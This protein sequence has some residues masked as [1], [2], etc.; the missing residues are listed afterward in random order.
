[1]FHL[2][3]ALAAWRRSLSTNRT[4]SNDDL[5]EL[6]QH[7]RDQIA[8]LVKNG[9]SEKAA[10]EQAMATMGEY[11]AV[12]REYEKVYWEK[13]W[14]RG[15]LQNELS[16]KLS[17]FKNY[18]TVA[19]RNLRKQKGYS[20]INIAGLAL[21]LTCF[22]LIGLFIRFEW[23]YDR[24]HAKADRI[25]RIEK[26]NPGH[27]YLERDHF[28]IT[29][30]PLAA[31]LMEEFPEVEHAVYLDKVNAGLAYKDNQFYEDGLLATAHFFEVFGFHLL[32]GDSHTALMEPNAIV[33]T[34]SLTQKYFGEETALG[35][36][37]TVT[38]FGPHGPD[39]LEM[40]VTGIIEDVP[41]N[42]HLV[43]DYITPFASSA[44]FQRNRDSWGTST[45]YTYATLQAGQPV[46][47]FANKLAALSQTYND[48]EDNPDDQSY[49]Y[50][51]V[52]THIHLRSNANF[53]FGVNGNITYVYL[54]G[55]IAVLILLIAS[56]NYVNLATARSTTRLMEVGVRKVM[57]AHRL[58]L[59][60]QFMGEALLSSMAALLLAL[61]LVVLLLP[62]FNALTARAI[63]LD[64]AQDGP[65]LALL[66]LIGF[67]IGT[68]AGSYPA[69][70]MSAFQPVRMMKKQ[71]GHAQGKTTLRNVLVVAQFSVTIALFIGAVVIQRQLHYIQNA[72]SGIDRDHVVALP[73][74]DESLLERYDAIKN[75]LQQHPA[76]LGVTA[77]ETDPTMIDMRATT[78]DW[79]GAP[80]GQQASAYFT[81]IHYGFV[82]MFGI[83]V[84]EGRDFS[85]AITTDATEGILINETLK[86]QLG[87]D[88]AIG[89]RLNFYGRDTHVIGVVQDFTFQ[90]F[91]QELAPLAL[92]LAPEDVVRILI[93]VRPSNTPQTIN[94]IEDALTSFSPDFPF[95]YYFL[96]DAYNSMYQ[97]ELRLGSLFNTFTLL[98]LII[99]CL[100][101]F[102]LATLAASQRT[103]EIGVRKVLGA[104]LTDVLV[105][106][107]KDFVRLV[108][109]ALVLGM[110]IAYFV[111]RTWLDAFAYHISLSWGTFV[112]AGIAALTIALLTV[113]YQALKAALADPVKSL[114]YE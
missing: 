17:M 70:V 39:A 27:T 14:R 22:I 62:T 89:K 45:S 6:E 34:E 23:S 54:F 11:G 44:M 41:P 73:I 82:D 16:W 33:L 105:L 10:F 29:P 85:E 47:A 81:P 76:I 28:A 80:E 55:A 58:Q 4:F 111:M 37:I 20:F 110:P 2:D 107:S 109:I 61:G 75:A 77:S 113:S 108:G 15:M 31:V 38:Y 40:T 60:S 100:G 18:L 36:A 102:G 13:L 64:W 104:T 7:L 67:V 78:S 24:F 97:T 106:L 99:A 90:S 74:K 46:S 92:L 68:L 94:F 42:S 30:A 84:V 49:Y 72:S 83:E 50:P 53:E 32:H 87:W 1:M 95:E 19:L 79:E 71:V 69:L 9:Q 96:D 65:F 12:E 101:L 66:A 112:A 43:F 103:K 86:R 56:I 88:T 8:A 5:D 57:G 52:L 26:I 3:T 63:T 91:R 25:Y 21:G 98:A 51:Q 93:K 114:R 59:V 48:D 35:K